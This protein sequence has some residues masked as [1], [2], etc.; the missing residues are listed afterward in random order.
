MPLERHSTSTPTRTPSALSLP[1][2]EEKV[3]FSTW[4]PRRINSGSIGEDIFH[5]GTGCISKLP[6]VSRRLKS[7]SCLSVSKLPRADNLADLGGGPKSRAEP[8]DIR[9]LKNFRIEARC[10]KSITSSE[11]WLDYRFGRPRAQGPQTSLKSRTPIGK[12]VRMFTRRLDL[13]TCSPRKK[14]AD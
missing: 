11:K 10:C 3:A 6:N 7:T 2:R 8:S 13:N 5:A 12:E 14:A 9:R 1:Y 4:F